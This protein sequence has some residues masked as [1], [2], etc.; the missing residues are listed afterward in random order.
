[1]ILVNSSL[2]FIL[3]VYLMHIYLDHTS[4]EPWQY[5]VAMSSEKKYFVLS[6]INWWLYPNVVRYF[7]FKRDNIFFYLTQFNNQE[8]FCL[9]MACIVRDK[10]C[11]AKDVVWWMVVME[12]GSG[13]SLSPRTTKLIPIP[14]PMSAKKFTETVSLI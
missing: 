11:H 3:Y 12:I 2:T 14:F 1:M 10:V 13:R 5:L 9:N 7:L 4:S 6:Y 8:S